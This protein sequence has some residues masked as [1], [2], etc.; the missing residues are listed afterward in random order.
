M[1]AIR[2]TVDV[3][4]KE[5][6]RRRAVAESTLTASAEVLQAIR[7]DRLPKEAPL[8]TARAAGLLA[9]KATPQLIPHCHPVA[10]TS[11]RVEFAFAESSLTVV[12]EVTAQDR[13]GPEMEALAGATVAALTLYDMIK[14]VFRGARIER[15]RLREKEGGKS[16]HWVA[17]QADD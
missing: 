15:I 17:E 12:C 4:D 10:L 13:T 2:G 7:E 1:D 8:A 5:V 14:G 3:S 11:V 16:G 6:T 9:A